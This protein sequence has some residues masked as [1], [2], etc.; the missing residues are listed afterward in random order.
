VN[1]TSGSARQRLRRSLR[2]RRQ[3]LS[4]PQRRA[5]GEGVARH[6]F[7]LAEYRRARVIAVYLA[8]DGELP[9]DD[10][11]V[12]A[13]RQGK[14][15]VAPRLNRHGRLEFVPL[16]RGNV[17]RTNSLGIREPAGRKSL[18]ARRLDLVLTPLVAFD[19]RGTR[20]GMGGGHYDRCFSFL[21]TGARRRPILIGIGYQFQ[22]VEHLDRKPWDVPLHRAITDQ[23]NYRFQPHGNHA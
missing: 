11:I 20:L 6:L 7:R 12:T 4:K 3:A 17:W 18:P 5:A 21:L 23:A 9:L 15:L 13:H 1:D 8:F 19:H 16:T 10:L 22:R 14:Q 2:K